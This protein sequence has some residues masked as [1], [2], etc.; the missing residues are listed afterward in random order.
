M[1]EWRGIGYGGKG[2]TGYQGGCEIKV[3]NRDK[4]KIE[5]PGI[6]PHRK[7]GHYGQGSRQGFLRA[8]GE[9]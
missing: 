3:R 5:R 6:G 7:N 4:N 9:R 2:G 1:G 8:V